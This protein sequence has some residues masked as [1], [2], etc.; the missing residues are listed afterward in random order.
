M[1]LEQIL[2][3]MLKEGDVFAYMVQVLWLD[4]FQGQAVGIVSAS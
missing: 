4:D 3:G 1:G 2:K